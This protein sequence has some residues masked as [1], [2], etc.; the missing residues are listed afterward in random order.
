MSKGAVK[1]KNICSAYERYRQD[2]EA[3]ARA[4]V[5]KG[6]GTWVGLQE[7]AGQHPLRNGFVLFNSPNGFRLAIRATEVTA[8]SIRDTISRYEKLFRSKE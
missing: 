6:G 4:C 5:E 1:L 3:S 7:G 2:V 8:K